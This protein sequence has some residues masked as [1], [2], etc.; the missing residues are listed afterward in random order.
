[1]QGATDVRLT[2]SR[3]D[4]KHLLHDKELTVPYRF[5]PFDRLTF[6]FRGI[7]DI[8]KAPAPMVPYP[9]HFRMLLQSCGGQSEIAGQN[10]INL[11]K[12]TTRELTQRWKSNV[13]HTP[14]REDAMEHDVA[15]VVPDC[16]QLRIGMQ[17][18]LCELESLRTPILV[19]FLLQQQ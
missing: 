15:P 19:F 9:I 17:N 10:I 13:A 6:F 5:L 14:L 1:M 3:V 16:V 12:C 4:I 8:F 7:G 2:V 11:F 18:L